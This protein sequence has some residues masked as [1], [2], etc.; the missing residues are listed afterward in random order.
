MFDLHNG[1]RNGG[2]D[3]LRTHLLQQLRTKTAVGLLPLPVYGAGSSTTLF[4]LI[5][6]SVDPL[7]VEH[8]I[9]KTFH[10]F[11]G[12]RKRRLE[13]LEK[14][15]VAMKKKLAQEPLGVRILVLR[16][17]G[18]RGVHR[19]LEFFAGGPALNFSK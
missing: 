6:G 1:S 10:V 18:D 4:F 16:M 12:H 11:L 15:I 14:F 3:S 19:V 7:D 8:E 13:F 17:K 5:Q 2:S 9:S